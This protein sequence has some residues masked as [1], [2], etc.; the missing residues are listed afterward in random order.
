MTTRQEHTTEPNPA[1]MASSGIDGL[2]R[3]LLGGFVRD[4]M[5]LVQGGAGTGKTTLALH[6][7]LA[8]IMAGESGLYITLSQTKKGLEAIARSHGWSLD[9]VTVLDLSPSSEATARST[10][11]TVLHTAEV[12]LG[13]L[14]REL[15][16]QVEQAK[17]RRIVFDSLG[18]IS[19][20]AGSLPRYHRAIVTLRQFLAG[21]GCTVLF[22]DDAPV[23]AGGRANIEFHS[24]ATSI[25]HLEQA[26]PDYGEVRRRVRA[27]KVRG[28]SFRGGYHDF[29]IVTG[30]LT[31]FPRLEPP[32]SVEYSDFR[33]VRSGIKPLD[34]LLGGGLEQGTT[35][36][37][38]GPSGAGKSTLAGVFVHAAAQ[39][40]DGTAI[41]LFD[42][43]PETWKVRARGVG[44]D[45]QLHVDSQRI[46][47]ELVD[48]ALITPG[49]FAQR[50]SDAVDQRRVKIVVIDSLTGYFNAMGNA[51][52]LVVQM[53]EL[54]TFLS[55]RGV[56]TLLLVAQEGFMSVGT[57]L[58]LDVSY[59]SDTIIVVRLFE[60]EGSVRRCLSAVKKRQ[61]EH[62]TTIRELYISPGGVRIGE[63]PL[64][65]FRHILSGDPEPVGAG[66]G[67]GGGKAG[68]EERYGSA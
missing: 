11:Q 25:L 22:L 9:G 34:R 66:Q 30:G 55:R 28:V 5:H 52:M 3:I 21:H 40:G 12:E 6:Y 53:H 54:I 26:I 41:F 50:V 46:S 58:P 48:P 15:R 59:L 4:E 17:P 7:L 36:F 10:H 33:Q 45:L 2:D 51:A 18:V 62:E 32:L 23:E 29:R 37:L 35:C 65:Q 16:E 64:R 61:G 1:Q 24:L 39:H 57:R 20:L 56:L 63:E 8:G 38:V 19:L 68:D 60:A 27:V 44:M 13:E 49:E 42:E 67:E 43:R 14:T 47:L 31:V